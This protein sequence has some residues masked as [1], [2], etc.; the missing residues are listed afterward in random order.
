MHPDPGPHVSFSPPSLPR[1]GYRGRFAPSPTGP[2]HFGSLLAALGSWLLARRVGGEWLVRIEDL[3][4]PREV[5]GAVEE[6]L[7]TLAAF[8]LHADGPVLRQRERGDVYQA[9][10]DHLLAS[11]AALAYPDLIDLAREEIGRLEGAPRPAVTLA[12][13]SLTVRALGPLD[14]R[15]S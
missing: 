12:V 2:L 4:P 3:D 9:A 14:I 13:P 8:G 15:R 11:G 5:A 7:R 6:Q 10:L 1:S